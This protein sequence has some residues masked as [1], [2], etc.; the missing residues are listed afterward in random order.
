MNT[1]ASIVLLL[2]GTSILISG[3]LFKVLHWP[4][5][6]IQLLLGSV[7]QSVSLIMLAIKVA[8]G[9]VS[10]AFLDR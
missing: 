6:N 7:L 9:N 3:S 2:L 10:F 4:S 8:R 5:A 1:R